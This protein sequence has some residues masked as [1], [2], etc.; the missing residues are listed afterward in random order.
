M[1][2]NY[3]VISYCFREKMKQ[4]NCTKLDEAITSEIKINMITVDSFLTDFMLVPC[5]YRNNLNSDLLDDLLL[6]SEK[7]DFEESVYSK[8]IFVDSQLFSKK[9]CILLGDLEFVLRNNPV[10]YL[11]NSILGQQIPNLDKIFSLGIKDVLDVTTKLGFINEVI[12]NI[13][14]NLRPI[15]KRK[16][17]LIDISHTSGNYNGTNVLICNMIEN[18]VESKLIY[19]IEIFTGESRMLE[20][21][22]DAD[23]LA[24]VNLIYSQEDLYLYEYGLIPHQPWNFKNL[25]IIEKHCKKLI[26]YFLDNIYVDVTNNVNYE[27]LYIWQHLNEL[28]EIKLFLSQYSLNR[29]ASISKAMD[30]GLSKVL[31]PPLVKLSDFNDLIMEN[32]SKDGMKGNRVL[33][34]GNEYPHKDVRTC[35]DE[36]STRG[37]YETDM[38]R[39]LKTGGVRKLDGYIRYL[40]NYKVVVYPSFYE[41]FGMVPLEAARLGLQVFVRENKLNKEIIESLNVSSIISTFQNYIDL[42]KQISEYFNRTEI[43]RL[44]LF[45][46][47]FA[48]Y[49]EQGKIWTDDFWQLIKDE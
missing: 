38:Y 1:K 32:L 18:L 16:P 36:L 3:K 49:D 29:F 46:D 24:R 17:I 12:G 35:F 43:D 26:T 8:F 4:C 37:D 27:T 21:N 42:D 13:S 23:I 45:S 9:E 40:L 41:G 28:F 25:Y 10:I 20:Q 19:N 11:K 47:F 31:K 33:V 5:E 6:S 7:S 22:L 44:S 14:T 30:K 39:Q 15:L 2:N 34:L 48:K